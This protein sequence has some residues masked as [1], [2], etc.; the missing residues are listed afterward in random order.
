VEDG[1]LKRLLDAEMEAEQVVARADKERQ[2][3]IEQATRAAHELEQQHA[4]RIAE[5]DASLLAQAQLRA[6]QTIATMK[7]RYG[8]QA[9]A[10]RASAQRHEQQALAKALALLTGMD[11]Q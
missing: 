6:Q 5:I 2:A 1:T 7:R 4:D 10:I 11:R 8:E 3:I 9:L